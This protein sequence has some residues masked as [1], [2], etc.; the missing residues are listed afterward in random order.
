MKEL[1]RRL[2]QLECE[3]QAVI[4]RLSKRL[5]ERD[6]S[7]RAAELARKE[8]KERCGE[9]T[10]GGLLMRLS[11]QSCFPGAVERDFKDI[12]YPNVSE[13]L[14]NEVVNYVQW[15]QSQLNAWMDRANDIIRHS[16]EAIKQAYPHAVVVMYG[17]YHTGLFTPW[18]D[19]DINC[20]AYEDADQL[21]KVPL[22][23]VSRTLGKVFAQ[24][25]SIFKEVLG[26]GEKGPKGAFIELRC[27]SRYEERRVFINLRED[28]NQYRV[29]D[30]IQRYMETFKCLKP[31]YY[32]LVKLFANLGLSRGW[33]R[34]CDPETR[35]LSSY[36]LILMVVAMFQSIKFQLKIAT[37][38]IGERFSSLGDILMCFCNVYG[39]Q[40]DLDTCD[41]YPGLPG[42]PNANPYKIRQAA[43]P[44]QGFRIY[45]PEKKQLLI[46]QVRWSVLLKVR[47]PH[48][49]RALLRLPYRHELLRLP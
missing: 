2:Q 7:L 6:Q 38:D 42:E 18:S 31:L 16:V 36:G 5:Q 33:G 45:D 1:E 26:G 28:K 10:R 49:A 39:N 19:F 35:G 47:H 9:D 22:E 41:L 20:V 15:M 46:Q 23:V 30:L 8:A 48:P 32:V 12:H 40:V 34:S 27:G 37:E 17:E 21:Q 3:E 24:D 14:H 29:E 4:A 44:D 11:C 43:A 13:I 25:T